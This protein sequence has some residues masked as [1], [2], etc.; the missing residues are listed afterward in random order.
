[1]T[2]EIIFYFGK[3]DALKLTLKTLNESVDKFI[4]IEAKKDE[5]GKEKPRY[6]FQQERYVEP[7]WKKI[8][9]YVVDTM[10]STEEINKILK[11]YN[12]SLDIKQ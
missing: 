1:M 12:L 5:Q 4:I 6:F 11:A 3:L 8:E 10:E 7:Y 9:Y 2:Y